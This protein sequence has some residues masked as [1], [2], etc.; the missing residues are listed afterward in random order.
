LLKGKML[1]SKPEEEKEEEEEEDSDEEE[2][3]SKGKDSKLK[4]SKEKPHKKPKPEKTAKEL[5]D[6]I[7]LGTV[8]FIGYNEGKAKYKPWQMSS[9]SEG[10]VK[11]IDYQTCSTRLRRLQCK[12]PV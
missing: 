5:S 3:D 6:L 11:K 4:D 7:T 2:K 1:S 10:K 12:I 9:F 8:S